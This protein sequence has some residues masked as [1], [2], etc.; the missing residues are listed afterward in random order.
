MVMAWI[1]IVPP[2]PRPPAR[3]LPGPLPG[4]PPPAFGRDL[5]NPAPRRGRTAGAGARRPPATPPPDRAGP[6]QG[7][8]P[9]RRVRDHQV[10]AGL[11]GPAPGL[12]VRHAQEGRE[13]DPADL[14][15]HP[16]PRV[17]PEHD[18]EMEGGDGRR[19]LDGSDGEH[20][21]IAAWH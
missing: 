5:P 18:R 6:S 17:G 7:P 19:G 20:L 12:G 14:R 10:V 16:A 13:A 4:R 21:L 2:S 3:A 9:V 11:E 1:A 8:D 15:R